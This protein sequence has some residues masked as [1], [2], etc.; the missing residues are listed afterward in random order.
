MQLGPSRGELIGKK[1][2]Y[3]AKRWEVPWGRHVG[4]GTVGSSGKGDGQRRWQCDDILGRR[5]EVSHAESGR[6]AVWGVGTLWSHFWCIPIERIFPFFKCQ[7]RSVYPLET[8]RSSLARMCSVFI[9]PTMPLLTGSTAHRCWMNNE[10]F[11][12]EPWPE[13][14]SLAFQICLTYLPLN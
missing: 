4:E 7:W 13:K 10:L 11:T 8:S 12:K 6:Q 1:S 5:E 3:Y 2:T 9:S 14:T